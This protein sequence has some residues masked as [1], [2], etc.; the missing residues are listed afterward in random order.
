MADLK[1]IYVMMEE[2]KTPNIR[3]LD[4]AGFKI[5]QIESDTVEE[6]RQKMETLLPFIKNYG[7]VIVEAANESVKKRS[8]QGAFR[9][10]LEF[11]TAAGATVQGPANPWTMG[12]VPPGYVSNEVMAA[13]L[14]LIQAQMAHYRE[15]DALKLKMKDDDPF[16]H[17]DKIEKMVPA[18]MYLAGKP[19]EEIKTFATIYNTSGID[20][21]GGIA[22]PPTNTLIFSDVEKLTTEQKAARCQELANELAQH[23]S[24]EHMII[25]QE[26]L[27]AKLKLDPKFIN[28]I[29]I[30][31]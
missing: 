5:F 14:D 25:L 7:K 30:Y 27:I 11:D 19:L 23:I 26:K 15:L 12:A 16:K 24:I 22:G 9:W 21:P 28:T 1:Q 6:T 13:K 10:K 31:I 3:I 2:Q 18:L 29:F 8:Y 20:A 17:M 4:T